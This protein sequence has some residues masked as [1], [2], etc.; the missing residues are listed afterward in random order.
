M[1]RK[2]YISKKIKGVEGRVD[3]YLLENRYEDIENGIST[4]VFGVEICKTAIDEYSVEF[5]QKKTVC[6]LSVDRERVIEF[7]YMIA[8][9]D[10]LPVSLTDI[11]ADF[12]GEGFFQMTESKGKTA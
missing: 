6:D 10:V 7:L 8:D 2:L 4:Y 11:V 9:N 3:Y 5:V 1:N 12:A